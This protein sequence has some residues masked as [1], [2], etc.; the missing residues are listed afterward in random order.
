MDARRRLTHEFEP[1]ATGRPRGML[2]SMPNPTSY[3]DVG[4]PSTAFRAWAEAIEDYEKGPRAKVADTIKTCS[5]LAHAGDSSLRSAG[6]GAS[7]GA[8]TQGDT[9]AGNAST[10]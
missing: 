1:K 5:A 7:C 8:A 9:S 2:S 3:K 6:T 4:D 10:T